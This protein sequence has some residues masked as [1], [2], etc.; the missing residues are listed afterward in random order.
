MRLTTSHY[1]LY[2]LGYTC[3][4]MVTTKSSNDVNRS[5]S[6]KVIFQFGLYFVTQVHEAGIASNRIWERYGE[7][8][9]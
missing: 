4:T 1:G 3:A 9:L 8:V 2:K 6:I 5:K 7:W